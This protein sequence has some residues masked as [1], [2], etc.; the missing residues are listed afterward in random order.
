MIGLMT[1]MWVGLAGL[2]SADDPE[3]NYAAY[4][5][6]SYAPGGACADRGEMW[7]LGPRSIT[8]GNIVCAIHAIRDQAGG[9]RVQTRDC[10]RDGASVPRR[11]Y[12][13]DLL[14]ADAIKG[15]SPS[16]AVLLRRCPL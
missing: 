8:E 10:T 12:T 16:A 13:F 6:G 9:I 3:G 1:A 2:A 5:V 11:S 15:Q 7:I 4:Y 14:S